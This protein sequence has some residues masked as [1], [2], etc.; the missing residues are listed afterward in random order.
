MCQK[1]IPYECYEWKYRNIYSHS[2]R[3]AKKTKF[4]EPSNDIKITWRV[5]NLIKKKASATL[6]S[7]FVDENRVYTNPPNITCAFNNYFVNIGSLLSENI[8]VLLLSLLLSSWEVATLLSRALILLLRRKLRTLLPI[9]ELQ[10]L[11]V[12]RSCHVWTSKLVLQL[13]GH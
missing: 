6:P 1:S 2:I 13:S 10:Q 8:E 5:I 9:W 4:D 11:V 7:Q 12:M 3:L